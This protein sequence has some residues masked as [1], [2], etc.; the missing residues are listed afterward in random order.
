MAVDPTNDAP[1]NP[2]PATPPSDERAKL[3]S[4]DPTSVPGSAPL[5]EGEEPSHSG[6]LGLRL[7]LAVIVIFMTGYAIRDLSTNPSLW[8]W[9]ESAAAPRP[10][11]PRGELA[12]HEQSNIAI[13]DAASPSVVYVTTLAKAYRRNAFRL[14]TLRIPEGNGSGVIWDKLGHIVTNYHVIKNVHGGTGTCEVSLKNGET[15][16][17]RL[18]GA[19]PA[20]DLAVLQIEAPT[21]RLHPIPIGSS[22]DLKVGQHVYVIGNPLGLGYTFTAGMVSALNREIPAANGGVLR[23]LIQT[24]AAINPGNSG[25]PLLDSAGRMIGLATAIRGDAQNIGFGIPVDTINA[26]VPS[27]ISRGPEPRRPGLGISLYPDVLTDQQGIGRGIVI[28]HVL[29]G[30]NADR[31]GLRGLR[32][33]SEP[34]GAWGLGDVI[35]NV[36]GRAVNSSKDLDAILSQK[37]VGDP[38]ELEILREGRPQTIRVPLQAV[39]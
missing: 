18:V 28:E 34:A 26:I 21:D 3:R 15:W 27:L 33:L 11:E 10:I 20:N 6:G 4:V 23:N 36:D 37:K 19:D 9:F 16:E 24:D 29:E 35:L 1:Q 30:T 5:T 2:R 38:V 39:D 7:S 14:E 25:G 22:T 13:F 8:R 12:P 31:A 17:A 32:P